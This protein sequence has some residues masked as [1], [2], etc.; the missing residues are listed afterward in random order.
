MSYIVKSSGYS[1]QLPHVNPVE[2]ADTTEGTAPSGLPIL[3]SCFLV[4]KMDFAVCD[5]NDKW[6]I[7]T[8]DGVACIQ[9]GKS[10]ANLY[11][12]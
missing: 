11:S 4:D 8:G 3:S 7:A 9:A 10:W 2:L 5:G 6:Y 12:A 1:F